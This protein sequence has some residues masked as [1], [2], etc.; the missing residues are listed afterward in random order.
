[1]NC[2]F[3]CF[4]KYI[5]ASV[6]ALPF[7]RVLK[8]VTVESIGTSGFRARYSSSWD[9]LLNFLIK[10]RRRDQGEIPL[11]GLFSAGWPLDAFLA[12][13]VRQLDYQGGQFGGR[14]PYIGCWD[15]RNMWCGWGSWGAKDCRRQCRWHRRPR[16]GRRRWWCCS[17]KFRR[18]RRIPVWKPLNPLLPFLFDWDYTPNLDFLNWELV[19]WS[20]VKNNSNTRHII[21]MNLWTKK[22]YKVGGNGNRQNQQIYF[23]SLNLIFYHL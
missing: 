15:R 13:A 21:F 22:K 19:V 16:Q 2:I 11:V 8:F 1:M 17:T 5:I 7:F 9:F 14:R 10:L 6:V 23:C 3:L 20:G 4:K 18:R 12:P